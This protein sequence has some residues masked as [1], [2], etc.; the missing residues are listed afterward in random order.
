MYAVESSPTD[1]KDRTIVEF[2]DLVQV[3]PKYSQSAE[4]HMRF[5]D[6]STRWLHGP[7]FL[8]LEAAETYISLE[9]E[10]DE[11]NRQITAAKAAAGSLTAKRNIV[12]SFRSDK[13]EVRQ[14]RR[15]QEWQA[16]TDGIETLTEVN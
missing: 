11:L 7:S 9:Q 6:G 3:Y 16:A 14:Y 5:S 8:S 4:L 2:E 10:I 13:P 15:R 12:A 1:Y